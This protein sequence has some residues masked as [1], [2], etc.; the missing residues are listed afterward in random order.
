MEVVF[1]KGKV[2]KQAHVSLPEGT[3]EEEHGRETFFGRASHLYRAHPPTAWTRIEGPL[4]P[5]AFNL[6]EMKPDDRVDANATWQLVAGNDEVRLY[7]SRRSEPMPYFLRDADGDVCYFVHRGSGTIE[8]DYGPLS[9]GVGDYVIVP[10]GTTHRVVPDTDDNFFFVIEGSGEYRI[11]DRGLMGRHAQF[12]PGVLEVPEPDP[13]EEA[14]E[15]EVRVKRD[16]TFTSLFFA[17]HPLDVVGWQG[18]L[19]PVKLNV[20]QHRPVYSPSYHMPPSAHCTFANDGFV[21]CSF[22]PRPLE[23]DPEV[24]KVPFY[25]ANIDADEV[26]FYHSGNYF[27]RAGIDVGYMTLHPQGV[28]HGPQPAAI[29]KAKSLQRT[30]EVAVMVET[31]KPL[32]VSPEGHAVVITE[33]E[34]SWARGMGLLDE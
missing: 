9:Y 20:L 21:I 7:V 18:D 14:G 10:K 26:L 27:S 25:H 29:E 19:C 16:G 24:L 2:A 8:T 5:R 33:Y 1:S 32:V 28:H 22:V 3:F 6:N 4:R 17:W 31:E 23:E 13:H 15:F 34:T 12:D 11:P 30:E